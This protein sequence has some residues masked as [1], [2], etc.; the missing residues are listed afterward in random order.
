MDTKKLFYA[1]FLC[2]AT[3]VAQVPFTHIAPANPSAER[4]ANF[5]S[6]DAANDFLEITNSTHYSGQFIPSI[7]GHQ[8]GDN[9]FSLRLFAT[10]NSTQ[11]SGDTP[12]MVFRTDIRNSL[13][14]SAP[15]GGYY[16]P[17]GEAYSNVVNRP[18]FGW[19]NGETQLMRILANGNVG[20]NTINPTEKLHVNGGVKLESLPTA[21][22]NLLTQT[23]V[24][25]NS[26]K[27]YKK[28]ISIII[29]PSSQTN[30][31]DN[32]LEIVNS[33]SGIQFD[34]ENFSQYAL[35]SVENGKKL[36]SVMRKDSEQKEINYMEVIP[37]LVEAVKEQ[38]RQINSLQELLNQ[39]SIVEN[40]K[41]GVTMRISNIYPNPTNGS[42]TIYLNSEQ[43]IDDFRILV[44]TISGDIV[45]TYTGNGGN[46][47]EFSYEI[48]CN[49]LQS[50]A[51]LVVLN[52][53]GKNIETQRLL[54]N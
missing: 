38:Q 3:A 24:V 41:A 51:Y 52:V 37:I 50:G 44:Y 7:W 20:I 23:L 10:T 19:E 48:D 1:L 39:K 35:S 30:Q 16:F 26:G 45:R 9:R 13:N 14:L 22:F 34:V 40:Q 21:P 47:K 42:A 31:I 32:A 15:Q 53:G 27:V 49:G 43:S 8:Q 17:W 4:V 2:G 18:L 25:D 29:P 33:M 46:A 54:V 5:K 28:P 6:S 11:D 12:I 36:P